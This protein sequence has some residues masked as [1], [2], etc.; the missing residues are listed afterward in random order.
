M[1]EDPLAGLDFS[2]ALAEVTKGEVVKPQLRTFLFEANFPDAFE[3]KFVKGDS[4]RASDGWFWPSTHPLWPEKMLYT[5]LAQPD[6][7]PREERQYMNVLSLT[8]GSAVHGFIETCLEMMGLRPK[9]LNTC[10]MC[11]PR[12]DGSRCSE[13]GFMH[14]ETGSRGHADGVLDLEGLVSQAPV[15]EPVSLLEFKTIS[16]AQR[17]RRIEAGGLAH[18]I[19][20]FP[21]YYAQNQEYMRLSGIPSIVVVFMLMGFPWTMVELH[22][23]A[24]PRYQMAQRDKYLRVRDAVASDLPVEC[25]YSKRCPMADICNPGGSTKSR[26]IQTLLDRGGNLGFTG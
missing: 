20:A 16:N 10:T 18:Y 12:E 3:I 25:C 2:T 24:D 13:P 9:S 5:Y 26:R 19:E 8:M 23:P 11:P 6:I 22:V 14:E 1:G 4:N 15:L 7:L 21:E 17:L